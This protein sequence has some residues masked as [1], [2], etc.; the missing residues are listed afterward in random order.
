MLAGGG[1]A[2]GAGPP[3]RGAHRAPAEHDADGGTTVEVGVDS[4]VAVLAARGAEL[5]HP[6][7]APAALR[8]SRAAE[9][10]ELVPPT[11]V[12]WDGHL[13]GVQVRLPAGRGGLDGSATVHA[14]VAL[15]GGGTQELVA[16]LGSAPVV[17]FTRGYTAR[18]VGLGLL[19]PPGCHELRLTGTGWDATSVVISRP[20]RPTGRRRRRATGVSCCRCTPC[21]TR[22]GRG[23]APSPTW[24]PS[25]GPCTRG[26]TVVATLPLLACWLDG[27][28]EPN[29]Y[30]PASRLM[31]N[32]LFV[33]VAA[34]NAPTR[35]RQG[36]LAYQTLAAAQHDALSRAAVPV[37]ASPAVAQYARFRAVAARLG[38]RWRRWPTDLRR[39]PLGPGVG[40]P[41][42]E[43]LHR[44]AQR[45]ADRQL[46]EVATALAGRGQRL[47]LDL[48]LGT[49]PD[50][51]DCWYLPGLFRDDVTLG[52]PPDAQ[53]PHGQDW[54]AP[55]IDPD[56]SRRTGH[57]HLRD[58]LAHQMRHAGLLRLDRVG[59]LHHQWWIPAG[60][61]PSE[62]VP[63]RHPTEELFALV[64]LESQR[65]RSIVV[66][67]D[68]GV[69]PDAVRA[70]LARHGLL[71]LHVAQ[72]EGARPSARAV[73]AVNTPDLPTLAGWRASTDIADRSARGL[74]D[75]ARA[76]AAKEE[77]RLA[78][79]SLT[80]AVGV[81]PT[82]AA[83]PTPR[84]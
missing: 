29:P 81:P 60:A 46:G 41:T 72:F 31:W 4:L 5:A 44:F 52:A 30:A 75:P 80:A 21:G 23:W 15:E 8:A 79:R 77:R 64:C 59:G 48:P 27:R 66:G 84:R 58:C 61:R 57:A 82:T 56:A 1:S 42:T 11:I 12:A 16:E 37:S 47:L 33:D 6:D 68:R 69:V 74:L 9:W 43:L 65:H 7:D 32:E 38:R 63:V 70:A 39:P 71:R 49:H 14:E 62:G 83:R 55:A 73:A 76:A 51:F 45:E 50:S 10:R 17:A 3:V 13:A 18:F 34:P 20:P 25:P 28:P 26:G 19:L 78:W 36:L 53:F 67:E 35:P 24:R 22:T 54:G 2:A 40:D